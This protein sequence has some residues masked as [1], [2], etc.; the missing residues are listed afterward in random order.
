MTNEERGIMADMFYYLRDHN[1]PA[2]KG[3]NAAITFWERAT[4]DMGAL[5][6]EKW[7][8]H[9]L[10]MEVGTALWNYLEVKYN[11]Q[12]GGKL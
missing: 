11:A 8:N 3:T 4:K 10:A 9:P 12:D 1:E 7:R 5:I 2:A 6:G